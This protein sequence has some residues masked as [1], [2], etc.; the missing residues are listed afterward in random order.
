MQPFEFVRASSVSE[1]AGLLA[2]DPFKVRIIAG[3]TD[4]MG[5]VKEG[6]VAPATLVSL[7]GVSELDDLV[8]QSEGLWIGSMTTLD[9]LERDPEIAARYPALAQAVASV[10][11]PQIRNAG[12]LGGNLCQR[13]R[14]WYYRSPLFDCLK[15]GGD[16]CFAVDGS[17][18]YHA[19]LGG[20][21]CHIVHPSDLAV[22]LISLRADVTI[23][24][25]DG[26][27]TLPLEDFFIGPDRDATAETVL[28]PGELLTGVSVPATPRGHLSIYLK[29]KERQTQDFALASVALALDLSDG[30]VGD[31]RVTLGGVA[32]VPLRVRHAEEAVEGK[33]VEAIDPR[34]VGELA[35]R[36]A[37]PMRDNRFKVPLTASLVA[38]AVRT[39]L[40]LDPAS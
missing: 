31:A 12:T 1:A 18:K 2:S 8:L 3:G 6:V 15:K 16:T 13:P 17:N 4:L 36:D 39:L 34:A 38:R 23:A 40:G 33:A 27:R 7:Q 19:I 32:P 11:T 21:G 25:P 10:A 35:V 37:S 14:C 26:S 28:A 30:V 29:A 5:E 22:A 24:G 20:T 9:K